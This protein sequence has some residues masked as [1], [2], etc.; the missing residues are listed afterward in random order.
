MAGKQKRLDDV[1]DRIVA[2]KGQLLALKH[3]LYLDIKGIDYRTKVGKTLRHIKE[4]L[5]E[6]VGTSTAPTEYLI[7]RI[8][9]KVIKLAIYE[10]KC[11]I[12]LDVDESP[13][14]LTMANSMRADLAALKDMA[15]DDNGPDLSQYLKQN[16]SGKKK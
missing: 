6:Y 11:L 3:G 1:T 15:G 16:Y 10:Q 14:Y 13:I 9:Y 2:G 12:D 5:R 4:Q 7:Q 8:A